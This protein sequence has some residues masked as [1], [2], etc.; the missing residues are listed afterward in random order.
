MKVKC[1]MAN[2]A[3]DLQKLINHFIESYPEYEVVQISYS[4]AGHMSMSHYCMVMY[5]ERKERT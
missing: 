3:F 2:T 4:V 1:F 5:K